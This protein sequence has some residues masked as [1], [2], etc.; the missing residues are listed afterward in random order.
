MRDF[1]GLGTQATQHLIPEISGP[2]SGPGAGFLKTQGVLDYVGFL[3]VDT[4]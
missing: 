2:V 3:T 4:P 1:W